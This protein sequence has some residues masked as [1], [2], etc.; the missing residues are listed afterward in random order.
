MSLRSSFW[1][2]SSRELNRHPSKIDD[3]F[4]NSDGENDL[5]SSLK[6]QLA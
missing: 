1:I 5:A 4:A 2:S 3:E 6:K